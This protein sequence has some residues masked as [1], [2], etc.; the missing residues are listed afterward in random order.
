[1]FAIDLALPFLIFLPRRARFLA[2]GGFVFLQIG[3]ALT[4]NYT[5][6]NLLTIVLCL[7]LLDDATI[8]NMLPMRWRSAIPALG[9]AGIRQVVIRRMRTAAVALL[10]VVVLTITGVQLTATF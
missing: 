2:C 9:E 10:A 7:L 1:M 5:F 3:I 4:G 8:R 6:F